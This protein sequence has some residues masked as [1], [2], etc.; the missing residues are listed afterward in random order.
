[1]IYNNKRLH[2]PCSPENNTCIPIRPSGMPRCSEDNPFRNSVESMN[3][4]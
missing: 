2:F 4:S 1:V 3:P